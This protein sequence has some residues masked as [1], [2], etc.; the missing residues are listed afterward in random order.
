VTWIVELFARDTVGQGLLVLCLVSALGLALGAVRIKSFSLGVASILFVGIVFGHF[1]VRVNALMMDVA[2]DLGLILFVY[3]IGQEVGPGLFASLRRRG[4]VLNGLAAGIILLGGAIAFL[5]HRF[6][7]IPVAAAAGLFSGATTNT[8]SLAAIQQ[9]L[10]ILP[11]HTEALAR[12][13]GVAYALAYP[14]G[15]L[16]IILV[17]A[18]V[19][20][21]FRV[22][23]KK[24]AEKIEAERERE[25]P[26]LSGMDLEIRNPD[27]D[28]MSVSKLVALLGGDVVISRLKRG[29]A[30][31]EIP[32]AQ[33]LIRLGDD[34]HVVGT[35]ERLEKFKDLAGSLSCRDLLKLPAEL[36]SKRVLVT[37]HQALGKTVEDLKLR[38]KYGVVVT[39]IIRTGFEFSPRSGFRIQTGDVLMVVGQREAVETLAHDIGDVRHRT[40]IGNIIPIFAGI[41]VGVVLGSV[42]IAI[43]GMAVP[44]RIGLAGGPLVAAIVLS[45]IGRIGPLIWYLPANSILLLRNIGISLFLASVGIRAGEGF[46]ETLLSGGAV[47]ILGGAL[48][49]LVPLVLVSIAGM[50]LLKL[51]FLS[52][53]GLMA[54]SMTDPP[55]LEFASAQEPSSDAP[56]TS[57]V[58]VYPLTMLLRVLTAQALVL[59]LS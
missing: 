14:F 28:G 59:F 57:F 10:A 18:G 35:A 12:T 19:R 41:V 50:V 39:R 44:F 49:T 46:V 47:W 51:N 9:A 23:P 58:T 33:T 3:S 42:P 25:T 54:G 48:I 24:E 1:G 29:L 4:L 22:D 37:Q 6:G 36:T 40:G 55:A 2:R 31:I 32:K 52:L 38:E 11:A 53:C 5:L 30:P 13:P 15:V 56:L 16:G 20:T 7:G 34:L 21:A 45:R 26:K 27:L 43:P 8:P 17:M